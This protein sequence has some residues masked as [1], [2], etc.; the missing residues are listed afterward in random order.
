MSGRNHRRVD[1]EAVS[2]DQ[3]S[4]AH[5]WWAVGVVALLVAMIVGSTLVLRGL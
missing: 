3:G 2:K 5:L 4:R 1:W